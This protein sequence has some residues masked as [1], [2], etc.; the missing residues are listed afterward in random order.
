M[1]M[2]KTDKQSNAGNIVLILVAMVLGVLIGLMFASSGRTSL[3]SSLPSTAF[4][5]RQ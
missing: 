5:I 1:V 2:S 3:Q 4:T